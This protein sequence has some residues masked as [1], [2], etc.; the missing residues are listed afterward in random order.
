M[1]S[2]YN[3]LGGLERE[4]REGFVGKSPIIWGLV[5]RKEPY[6]SGLFCGNEP[7]DIGFFCGKELYNMGL[8]FIFSFYNYL[9]SS[10]SI[11][12]AGGGTE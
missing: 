3:Y 2:F 12:R 9:G 11:E 6:N 5:C 7:S 4:D 10:G 1:F 8:F